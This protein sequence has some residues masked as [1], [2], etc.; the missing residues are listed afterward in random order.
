MK[1]R[2]AGWQRAVRSQR[3]ELLSATAVSQGRDTTGQARELL[4]VVLD[5][6]DNI[7]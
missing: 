3:G 7:N 6:D 4:T 1:P 5:S 2:A